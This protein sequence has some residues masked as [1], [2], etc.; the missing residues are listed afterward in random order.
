MLLLLPLLLLALT[1]AL[2]ASWFLYLVCSYENMSGCPLS[3]SMSRKISNRQESKDKRARAAMTRGAGVRHIQFARL[4][5]NT[6]VDK[7]RDVV[8]VQKPTTPPGKIREQE[9]L[10]SDKYACLEKNTW[11]HRSQQQHGNK[12]YSRYHLG[13]VQETESH[14]SVGSGA[15]KHGNMINAWN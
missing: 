7:S 15:D 3:T 9:V 2:S 12:E 8:P 6:L 13:Y 1:M 11:H 4:H 10:Q 5:W 14:N